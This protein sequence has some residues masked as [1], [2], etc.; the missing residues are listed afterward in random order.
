M[1]A[2]ARHRVLCLNKQVRLATGWGGA[3]ALSASKSQFFPS[4]CDF[5]ERW[6]QVREVGS[7]ATGPSLQARQRSACRRGTCGGGELP[8]RGVVS[9]SAQQT[10]VVEAPI[11][12]SAPLIPQVS[13]VRDV[14]R[15]HAQFGRAL[16]PTRH[17]AHVEFGY[18]IHMQIRKREVQ[19]NP[20]HRYRRNLCQ[21]Q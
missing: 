5:P 18:S 11:E 9:T 3:C 10:C 14:S 16:A 15:S 1:R 17:L 2:A 6:K 21:P 19:Q 8:D 20:Q 4:F 12:R 7:G 13:P